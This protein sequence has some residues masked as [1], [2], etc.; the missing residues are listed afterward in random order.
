MVEQLAEGGFLL[1]YEITRPTACYIWG[2]D[3]RAWGFNDEREYGLWMSRARWQAALVAAGLV[4]VAEHWCARR[5]SGSF[6]CS[7][8]KDLGSRTIPRLKPACLQAHG[9]A[10]QYVSTRLASVVPTSFAC[11][12]ISALYHTVFR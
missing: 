9:T 1:T 5:V 7:S 8:Q 3:A 10:A 2:L 12:D 6:V 4:M 11:Q